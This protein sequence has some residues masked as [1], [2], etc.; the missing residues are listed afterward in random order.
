[1]VAAQLSIPVP[2]THPPYTE[3]RT[4]SGGR[5]PTVQ[6]DSTG[7]WAA[8]SRGWV[9]KSGGW[10]AKLGEWVAKLGDG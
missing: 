9:A 4:L 5:Y 2:S 7:G 6:G 8:K 10:V 3:I 1:M